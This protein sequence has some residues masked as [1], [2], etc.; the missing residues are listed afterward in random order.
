MN[1]KNNHER[2]IESE[3]NKKN[4]KSAFETLSLPPIESLSIRPLPASL[5]ALPAPPF[6]VP[7]IAEHLLSS[8]DSKYKNVTYLVPGEADAWCAALARRRP[9]SI[10]VTSDSDLLVYDLCPERS[11]HVSPKEI[12]NADNGGNNDNIVVIFR[13]ISFSRLEDGSLSLKAMQFSPCRI[14]SRLGIPSLAEL[15]FVVS[16]NVGYSLAESISRART[17]GDKQDAEFMRFRETYSTS[18]PSTNK[19]PLKCVDGVSSIKALNYG[20][21]SIVDARMSEYIHQ[22]LN[23][24]ALARPVK[25]G[26]NCTAAMYLPVLFED[27]ER[28]SAWDCGQDY[29]SLTYS[30]LASFDH[31]DSQI[32]EYRRYGPRIVG[33]PIPLLTS[34]EMVSLIEDVHKRSLTWRNVRNEY[35]EKTYWRLCAIESVYRTL[36]EDSKAL[37]AV[38]SLQYLLRGQILGGDWTFHHLS[39]QVK[40]VLYSVRMLKQALE[41]QFRL[42]MHSEQ[43]EPLY[44]AIEKLAEEVNDLPPLT[45]LLSHSFLKVDKEQN[46]EKKIL[47]K[48]YTVLGYTEEPAKNESDGRNKVKQR[49]KREQDLIKFHPTIQTS[50]PYEHLQIYT[51]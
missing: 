6:L 39:A 7:S 12:D 11:N 38:D 17:M 3:T 1:P 27:P 40:A 10:I 46:E 8:K 5:N 19:I 42:K 16:K 41:V 22:L 34:K 13:S 44:Q 26:V 14:A 9:G 35:N 48:L 25:R 50:N 4:S 30:I 15:A 47:E 36:M 51:D 45:T 18:L 33:K 43:T 20:D 24:D 28:S 37:P 29:R 49:K 23:R 2:E 32:V 31:D 21:T